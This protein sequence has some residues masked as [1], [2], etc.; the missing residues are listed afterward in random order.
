MSVARKLEIRSGGEARDLLGVGDE[1]AVAEANDIADLGI[2][3]C[4]V[5][6]HLSREAD[7]VDQHLVDVCI[8]DRQKRLFAA[9]SLRCALEEKSPIVLGRSGS[10]SISNHPPCA[11]RRIEFAASFCRFWARTCRRL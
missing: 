2:A 5:Y 7:R 6:V 8:A 11:R 9:L 1:V 10:S 4:D 3:A